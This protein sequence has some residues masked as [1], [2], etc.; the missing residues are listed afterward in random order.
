MRIVRII[1]DELNERSN[2][3]RNSYDAGL[4]SPYLHEVVLL[5]AESPTRRATIEQQ[6]MATYRPPGPATFDRINN[7]TPSI[8]RDVGAWDVGFF[9]V[10]EAKWLSQL[11]MSSSSCSFSSSTCLLRSTTATPS[12]PSRRSRRSRRRIL[13][14]LPSCRS[15][16][17][18]STSIR[19]VHRRAA[20][21]T[22]KKSR[23]AHFF[24]SGS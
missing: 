23:L 18:A 1:S 19:S 5:Y 14:L 4:R 9:F 21:L 15:I 7:T 8:L 2:S 12:S 6:D 22:H 3:E 24:P 13:R 16:I 20:R 11:Y 10:E 17:I